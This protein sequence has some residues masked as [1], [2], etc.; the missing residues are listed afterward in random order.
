MLTASESLV[1]NDSHSLRVAF[2][3]DNSPHLFRLIKEDFNNQSDTKMCSML[4]YLKVCEQWCN[5]V[6]WNKIAKF[7][8]CQLHVWT[9][10]APLRWFKPP[11]SSS[12]MGLVLQ[13]LLHYLN[14]LPAQAVMLSQRHPMAVGFW[15]VHGS[16]INMLL[17]VLTMWGSSLINHDNPCSPLQLFID[18]KSPLGYCTGITLAHTNHEYSMLWSRR[19]VTW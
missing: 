16:V 19:M 17:V 9:G 10:L 14:T 4:S 2:L 12:R 13:R 6:F 7:V 3:L 8:S 11:F 15:L 18:I 1:F 5:A